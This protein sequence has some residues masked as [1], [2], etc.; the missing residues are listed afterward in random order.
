MLVTSAAMG[1]GKTTV[2]FD[3]GEA[4]GDLSLY[5]SGREFSILDTPPVKAVRLAK[6]YI[7]R[8]VFSTGG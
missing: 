2:A 1:E 6:G 4:T 7:S 5:Y 8:S 3:P